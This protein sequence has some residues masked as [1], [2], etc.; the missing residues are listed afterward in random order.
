[1]WQKEHRFRRPPRRGASPSPSQP[2]PS[3][4]TQ[5]LSEAIS[6]PRLTTSR[7]ALAG[8]EG[9]LGHRHRPGGR[10]RRTP[11]DEAVR[12]QRCSGHSLP[13]PDTQ[14]FPDT[15]PGQQCPH[16]PP[17]VSVFSPHY[18]LFLSRPDKQQNKGQATQGC[19]VQGVKS[20]VHL[21]TLQGNSAE[22]PVGPPATRLP[23]P[24]RRST[25]YRV[26]PAGR[27]ESPEP[28]RP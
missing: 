16:S 13:P 18:P 6:S 24:G 3:C 22:S 27:Q 23:S 5:A 4:V 21:L 28:E 14:A 10:S 15:H 8:T 12:V 17:R 7:A 20:N 11:R 2:H 26:L 1:M 25:R 19:L 9:S